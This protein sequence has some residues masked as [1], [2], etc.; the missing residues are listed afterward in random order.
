MVSIE[1]HVFYCLKRPK[2]T[3]IVRLKS[4]HIMT[5]QTHKSSGYLFRVSA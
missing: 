1:D 5:I 4:K 3:Q 2:E